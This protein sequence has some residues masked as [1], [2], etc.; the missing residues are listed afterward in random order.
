MVSGVE[1][2]KVSGGGGGYSKALQYRSVSRSVTLGAVHPMF[3]EYFSPP[4]SSSEANSYGSSSLKRHSRSI[5]FERQF[6]SFSVKEN[7]P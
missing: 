3:W 5:S 1:G 6:I 7:P 2:G 4:K